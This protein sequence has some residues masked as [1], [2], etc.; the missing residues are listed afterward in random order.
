MIGGGEGWG[1]EPEMIRKVAWSSSEDG[2]ALPN[3]GVLGVGRFL[4]PRASNFLP[5][6]SDLD[7]PWTDPFSFPTPTPTFLLFLPVHGVHQAQSFL[8]GLGRAQ[9]VDVL[10]VTGPQAPQGAFLK[11]QELLSCPSR[12]LIKTRQDL[13][14]G[15]HR[16]APPLDP[17]RQ[18]DLL[19]LEL[20]Y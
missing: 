14:L 6:S 13:V 12:I 4:C 20:K 7:Q 5:L 2:G 9:S 3:T 16:S 1:R 11:S 8:G 18:G 10:A 15:R 19:A 17:S